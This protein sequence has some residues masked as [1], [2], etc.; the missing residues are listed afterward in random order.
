LEPCPTIDG[1]DFSFEA[2]P[3]DGWCPTVSPSTTAF[4]GMM[5]LGACI[6]VTW[7]YLKKIKLL[8]LLFFNETKS[9]REIKKI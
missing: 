9:G 1:V 3:N 8:L 2:Q 5:L 7:S 6:G 4:A